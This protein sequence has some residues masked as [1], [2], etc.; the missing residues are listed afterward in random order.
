[1]QISKHSQRIIAPYEIACSLEKSLFHW[2]LFVANSRSS[3]LNR[4][5]VVGANGQI[6][7]QSGLSQ[8]TLLKN[9]IRFYEGFIAA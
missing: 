8:E 6:P 7:L 2:S 1:M 9:F 5:W 4:Q 3:S